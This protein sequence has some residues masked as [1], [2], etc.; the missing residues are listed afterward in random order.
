MTKKQACTA[1]FSELKILI[2]FAS[3]NQA[4]E[5]TKRCE[6]SEDPKTILGAEGHECSFCLRRFA[7]KSDLE[8][9]RNALHT[10]ERSFGCK[11]CPKK[12][13][14]RSSLRVHIR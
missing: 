3:L 14:H 2:T 6:N 13:Y 12:F 9:H 7:F 11:E 4:P 8:A 5:G 10:R 1:L